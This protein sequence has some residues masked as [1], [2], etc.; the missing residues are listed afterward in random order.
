MIWDYIRDFI[1][2]YI[3]GGT[4]STYDYYNAFWGEMSVTDTIYGEGYDAYT[5]NE[6][7]FDVAKPNG[8]IFSINFCDWLATTITGVIMVLMVVLACMLVRW[9]FKLV[10][11]AFLLRR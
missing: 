4:T 3:T 2:Q 8:F 10:A 11:S 5:G 7:F 9:I 6:I 1:V